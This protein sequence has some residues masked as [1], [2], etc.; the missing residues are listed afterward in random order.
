MKLED[1]DPNNGND[2]GTGS[3][4]GPYGYPPKGS[5]T[6]LKQY[7][8]FLGIVLLAVIAMLATCGN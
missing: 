2:S 4:Q 8:P 1:I 3:G 6:K 5:K 7:W